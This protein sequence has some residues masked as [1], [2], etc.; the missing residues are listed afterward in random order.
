MLWLDEYERR[1]RL[2]P[3]LL[4]LLPIVIVLVVLGFR[5]DPASSMVPVVSLAGGPLVLA[6]IVRHKGKKAQENLW[7]S[8]GGAPTTLK[9]RLTEKG[10]NPLQRDAWRK[11]LFSVT[12]IDL[13]SSRSERAN[14]GKADH[15]IELA[16]GQ[17]RELTRDKSKFPLVWVENRGYGF[18]RNLY[19]IRWV[20]RFISLAAIL[21]LAAYMAWL[22]SIT[23]EPV[24]TKVNISA[25]AMNAVCL[26]SWLV[27]PSA[28]RVRQAADSYAYQLLQAAVAL[29]NEV[30]SHMPGQHD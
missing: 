15:A 20:G 13:A 4:A 7:N 9:L 19:G 2:V 22:A 8:W 3:G 10:Q 24:F 27:L 28:Q 29:K 14:I 18:Q 23:D 25:L 16:V 21:G 6:E 5:I 11:A 12:G 26:V 1:A 30:G 17:I